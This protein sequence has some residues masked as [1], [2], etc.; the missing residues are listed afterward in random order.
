[1][2]ASGTGGIGLTSG[3]GFFVR[4]IV[5][6]GFFG[7]ELIMPFSPL[8]IKPE[9]LVGCVVMPDSRGMYRSRHPSACRPSDA[10][11]NE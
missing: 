2:A 8:E 1:M 10:G 7:M 3:A 5:G 9:G 4:E 6:G 11:R